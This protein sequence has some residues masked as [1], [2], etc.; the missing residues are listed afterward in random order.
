MI[1]F[2]LS[3]I[4]EHRFEGW[5]QNKDDMQ[6]QLA[7]G[8]LRCPICE[9][10][11][12]RKV[13]AMA[14][15]NKSSIRDEPVPGKPNS[16][17]SSAGSSA[18]ATY[19]ASQKFVRKLHDYIDTNFIDVGNKFAEEARKIH[20]GDRNDVGIR[21]IASSEQVKELNEEGIVTLPLPTRPVDK[22]RLN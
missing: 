13:P 19:V 12:I 2:D 5:F 1:I 11:E 21:G 7:E 15:I 17:A 22:N 6:V 20:S 16:L 10:Q 4:D 9:N 14:K 8:L 18:A 3:C